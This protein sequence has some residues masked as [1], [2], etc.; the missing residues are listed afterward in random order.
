MRAE[1]TLVQWVEINRQAFLHNVREF[2]KRLGT[3]DLMAVIKANA[4]GH[5]LL[6]IARLSTEAGIDWFGVHSLEEG[7]ALRQ[8]GFR[9]KI[10]IL[11]YLPLAQTGEAVQAEL[12][13]TVYNLETV[14]AL[15]A[16]ARKLHRTALVH[17]KIETGTNRQG[18]A[19]NK[20]GSFLSWLKKTPEVKVEGV[21]SHFANIEDTTDDYY[22]RYQLDNFLQAVNFL[23]AGGL[24]IPVKHMSCS[25]AAI[26]FPETYF[27]L[28][29]VGIGLYG[30]WPSRETL[31]SCRLRGQE[32]LKLKPVLSW[33]ARVAQIKAVPCGTYIG[34]GCTYRTTRPTK[35]AIIPVG[36]YDGYDRGLSNSAYV[37]IKGK[38]AQVRGRVCMDFIMVDITDIPGVKLED[39]ATLL[40]SEGK[41]KILAD[42]LASLAG[43]ISYEIVTRINPLIPRLIV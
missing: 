15:A 42:Q 36:Y 40:G 34:Y 18:I 30:L 29:R 21:S 22:P 25:A 23:Q 43:T 38:R 6:E 13:V 31:V 2:Q 41:E 9:Q 4:Y 28:A 7:L 17:L 11:G 12:R 35:L 5:G 32:P 19:L 16:A 10:L 8:A 33:R 24:E 14:R 26:L 1:P 39:T 37:L 27:N 3:T 20:L